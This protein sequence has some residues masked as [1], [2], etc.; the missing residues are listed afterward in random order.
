MTQSISDIHGCTGSTTVPA[1]PQDD[2]R[3][4][5]LNTNE[6]D[7][8]KQTEH[9]VLFSHARPPCASRGV[10]P[11]GIKRHRT[12]FRSNDAESRQDFFNRVWKY[13]VGR[14]HSWENNVQQKNIVRDDATWKRC[15]AILQSCEVP[16]LERE[17]AL[18]TTL[19]RDLQGFSGHYKGADGACIGFALVEL[20]GSPEEAKES[21]VAERA[22][23]T[24]PEFNHDTVE[25]LIDYVFRK[26]DTK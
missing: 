7:R 11:K 26:Y 15:D 25:N 13:Q 19:S 10:I 1:H 20:F 8:N 5:L 18:R 6:C 4:E 21:W 14:G 16:E 3:F 24:V 12:T 9:A 22:A 17:S 23:D 2:D